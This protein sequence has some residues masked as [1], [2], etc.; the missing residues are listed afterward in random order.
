[1][2]KFVAKRFVLAGAVQGVGCRAQVVEIADGIGH[3]AGFVRNLTDG[4]VEIQ[5]KG[6]DWRMADFEKMIRTGLRP[7]VHVT[8]VEDEHLPESFSV[9]GFVVAPT[10]TPGTN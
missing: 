7:P 3:V 10:T 8:R 2:A 4:R 6:P 9:A 1:M 5:A